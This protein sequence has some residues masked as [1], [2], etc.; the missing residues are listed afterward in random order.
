MYVVTV[1]FEIAPGALQAFRAEIRRNAA[2]SLDE[3]G[4]SRFDVCFSPD[5]ARCFLYEIY[6][7]DAAFEVH[8]QTPHF[9]AFDQASA[10]LVTSKKVEIYLLE[11]P[12]PRHG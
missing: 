10:P 6:D 9:H 7:D 8:K 2:A 11:P 12:A 3:A 1:L 4:C 5:G